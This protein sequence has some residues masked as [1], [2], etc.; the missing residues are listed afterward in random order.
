MRLGV[1]VP[2]FKDVTATVPNVFSVPVKVSEAL[3]KVLNALV[4]AVEITDV[5][6]VPASIRILGIYTVSAAVTRTI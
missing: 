5:I 1:A 4:I 3:K 2:I 6:F